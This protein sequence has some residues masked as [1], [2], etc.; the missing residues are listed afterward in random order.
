[1]MSMMSSVL[2]MAIGMAMVMLVMTIGMTMVLLLTLAMVSKN[3]RTS[4]NQ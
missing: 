3:Y 4:T 1:M 2:V